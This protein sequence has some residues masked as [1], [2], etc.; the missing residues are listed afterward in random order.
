M[1][2]NYHPQ[3]TAKKQFAN[4][5]LDP[6]FQTLTT[7][8][9]VVRLRGKLFSVLSCLVDNQNNL[10]TRKQLIDQC[11]GGNS[12]TGEKAVTHAIC[13]LRKI[14][15]E[16]NIS[17]SITTLSKQG[18]VFTQV[19]LSNFNEFQVNRASLASK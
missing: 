8:N 15:R 10:V 9:K 4:C 13:Q 19:D 11:W 18:Y 3:S 7:P 6:A 12:F 2:Q 16:L 14:L 5:Q 17:V 1:L